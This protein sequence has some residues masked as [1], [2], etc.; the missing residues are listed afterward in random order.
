MPEIARQL[1]TRDAG[2]ALDKPG[3]QRPGGIGAAVID[4]NHLHAALLVLSE[5][6]SQVAQDGVRSRKGKG[7]VEAGDYNGQ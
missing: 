2:V 5:A 7:L 6:T 1:H 4:E 3:N